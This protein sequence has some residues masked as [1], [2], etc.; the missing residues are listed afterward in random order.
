MLSNIKVKL[1]IKEKKEELK[2]KG[3]CVLNNVLPCD[4]IDRL[5]EGFWQTLTDYLG[6][7]AQFSNRGPNRHFMAMPF[8]PSTFSADFFFNPTILE[9]IKSV[10]GERM[11]I[12]QWG[13]DTAVLGSE[14]Q[15]LHIDYQRPLFP[16][17]PNLLLPPYM[18]I[19]SFGLLDIKQRNG[20]IEIAAGTH[21]LER[22]RANCLVGSGTI[23]LQ[24]VELRKGD[25]LIRHPWAL[26]RGTP[27][28]TE[29][30]RTLVTIRYVRSWYEDRSRDVNPIPLTI[31]KNLTGDQKDLMRFQVV[32][33][34]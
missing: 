16:E 19:V 17:F 24:P 25:V 10:L 21:K 18:L 15:Q 23:S 5:R 1:N 34:S 6:K 27:N 4:Q 14:Y 13:C 32:N 20:A 9:M 31:W 29:T 12:D 30:P 8:N 33:D 3:F 7:N 11:V 2:L 26:H 22:E 28:F